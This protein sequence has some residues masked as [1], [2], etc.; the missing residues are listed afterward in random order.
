MFWKRWKWERGKEC[1]ESHKHTSKRPRTASHLIIGKQVRMVE[2]GLLST[3]IIRSKRYDHLL[4][5]SSSF[6]LLKRLDL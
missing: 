1:E 2:D 6:L 3:Q 4:L 5:L